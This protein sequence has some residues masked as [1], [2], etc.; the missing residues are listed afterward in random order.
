ML[1]PTSFIIY[2]ACMEQGCTDL[3]SIYS[4]LLF[5][6]QLAAIAAHVG[7]ALNPRKKFSSLP[8]FV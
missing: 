4:N 3:F 8:S 5:V 1:S 6:H 7:T 2:K